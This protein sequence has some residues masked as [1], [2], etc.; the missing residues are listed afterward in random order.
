M[1]PCI[2]QSV[3]IFY[4]LPIVGGEDETSRTDSP[5]RDQFQGHFTAQDRELSLG[6]AIKSFFQ[7]K[8]NSRRGQRGVPEDKNCIIRYRTVNHDAD[9]Q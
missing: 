3:R 1:E 2:A 9:I 7:S 8:G 4:K 5:V 6:A